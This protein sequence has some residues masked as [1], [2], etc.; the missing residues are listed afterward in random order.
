[1][2]EEMTSHDSVKVSVTVISYG[3]YPTNNPEF[4]ELS[5][6][7]TFIIHIEIW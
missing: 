1:M 5:T 2:D 6:M 7:K 4:P 3:L